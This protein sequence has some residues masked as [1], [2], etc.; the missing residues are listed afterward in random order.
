MAVDVFAFKRWTSE[1]EHGEGH[2][3]DATSNEGGLHDDVHQEWNAVREVKAID[4][5]SEERRY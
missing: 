5:Q 2:G 1:S 3:D 4:G